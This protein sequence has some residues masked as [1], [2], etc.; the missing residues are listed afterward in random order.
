MTRVLYLHPVAKF[1]GSSKSLLELW[2]ALHARGVGGVVVCP[3][4][5][6]AEQF[7]AAGLQV[8]LCAG[9]PLFDNSRYG[10][11]RGARWL[12]L[13]RELLL[14]PAGLLALRRARGLG[15]F[16]AIHINEIQLLT[17]GLV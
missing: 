7:A 9:L 12:V 15:P 2:K 8:E 11:Y 5:S 13:L 10:A 14:W 3:R 6:A 4:G 17:L 1:G 16:S